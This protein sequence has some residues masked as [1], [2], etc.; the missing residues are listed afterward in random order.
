MKRT[1]KI[2][3]GLI[4]GLALGISA[5]GTAEASTINDKEHE[6]QYVL[7]T[8]D[9][10][11]YIDGSS[12]AFM[13]R[14]IKMASTDQISYTLENGTLTISGTGSIKTTDGTYRDFPWYKDK[15]KI[16]SVVINDGITA[17]EDYAFMEYRNLVNISLPNS[18]TK[19]GDNAFSYCPRIE[20]IKI[21]DKLS[22]L[23]VDAFREDVSL[24]NVYIG[25][26]YWKFYMWK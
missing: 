19:I 13:E 24:K 14:N 12:N 7:V 23:G 26:G 22:Y 6:S 11:S 17:V 2:I 20:S 1:K 10:T 9:G 4:M 16:T 8:K 5:A 15:D 21:P 25:G 3:G 18:L